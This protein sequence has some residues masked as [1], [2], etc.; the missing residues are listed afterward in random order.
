MGM[1]NYQRKFVEGYSKV[2]SSLTDLLKKDKR[3][4]W[5]DKCQ[6]EVDDL[7]KRM[8]T[9]PILKLPNLERPF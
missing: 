8:V 4:S 1:A 7:K 9:T 2:T 5:T 3:W 6:K